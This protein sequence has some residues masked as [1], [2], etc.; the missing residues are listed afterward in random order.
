MYMKTY[1]FIAEQPS[2]MTLDYVC[3]E[4]W[5]DTHGVKLIRA[6]ARTEVDSEDSALQMEQCVCVWLF[7]LHSLTVSPGIILMDNNQVST[8]PPIFNAKSF[9]IQPINVG[10]NYQNWVW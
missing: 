2:D 8:P 5:T 4:D 10:Y 6:C 9:L 3:F 1:L 7:E